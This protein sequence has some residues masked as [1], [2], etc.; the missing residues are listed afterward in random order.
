MPLQIGDTVLLHGL[1]LAPMAGYTDYAMRRICREMGA[2]MLVS[3]MVSAKALVYQDS[4]SAPLARIRRDE[5]PAAV[6][7]FGSEPEVLA[8][9]LMR[10]LKH[11]VTEIKVHGMYADVDRHMLV[12]I[13]NKRQIGSPM[14]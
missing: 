6:Q 11:G 5:L 8:E 4:K 3:E 7:L 10:E 12:C 9:I 1:L 13:I 14:P 2:E